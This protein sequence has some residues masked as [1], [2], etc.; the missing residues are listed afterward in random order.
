M[1]QY[2]YLSIKKM[3]INDFFDQRVL[4]FKKMGGILASNLALFI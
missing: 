4:F 2:P 1:A 3:I